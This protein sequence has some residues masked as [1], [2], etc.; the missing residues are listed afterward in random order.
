MCSSEVPTAL[1]TSVL[2]LL[3]SP[4]SQGSFL[5]SMVQPTPRRECERANSWTRLVQLTVRRSVYGLRPHSGEEL[6]SERCGAGQW[7][8]TA[9]DRA[10][11]SQS[12]HK[13]LLGA[14]LHHL[15]LSG[16]QRRQGPA[17]LQLSVWIWPGLWF[18]PKPDVLTE[19][20]GWHHWPPEL[21]TPIWT[22]HLA[23]CSAIPG[24]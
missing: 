13:R 1:G 18:C 19:K 4:K 20:G 12:N 17:L 5:S 6:G 10:F 22:R 7:L 11:A 16:S 8:L 24:S 21:I 23:L 3:L 2:S 14:Q 15:D 9:D